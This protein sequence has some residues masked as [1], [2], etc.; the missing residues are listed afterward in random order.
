[1]SRDVGTFMDSKMTQMNMEKR[2]SG[3]MDMGEGMAP[4]SME[5]M[6]TFKGGKVQPTGKDFMKPSMGK[7]RRKLME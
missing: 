7:V 5:W 2:A 3:D 1:M 4:S 6:K